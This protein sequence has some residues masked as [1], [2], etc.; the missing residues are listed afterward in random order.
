LTPPRFTCDAVRFAA[1]PDRELPSDDLVAQRRAILSALASFQPLDSYEEER[2]DVL[3]LT[4]RRLE[5]ATH[6]AGLEMP[7]IDDLLETG[8][9]GALMAISNVIEGPGNEGRRALL[10]DRLL[11]SDPTSAR[12]ALFLVTAAEHADDP[13]AALDRLKSG[14]VDERYRDDLTLRIAEHELARGCLSWD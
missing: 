4:T 5:D 10:Y 14:G 11:R 3:L 13:L 7:F 8:D 2:R 12:Y 6:G 9:T 1:R